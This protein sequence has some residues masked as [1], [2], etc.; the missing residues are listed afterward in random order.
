MKPYIAGAPY[1]SRRAG[2]CALLLPLALLGGCAGQG[3][4]QSQPATEVINR[5]GVDALSQPPGRRTTYFKDHGSIERFCRD[6]NPDFATTAS[7]GV[8]LGIMPTGRGVA[9]DEARGALALGG[10]NPEVLIARELLYRAC[11]LTLNINADSALTLQI[12][13]RFL[14]SIEKIA[15]AQTG[16]G[17]AVLAGTAGDTRTTLVTPVST[18]P[19]DLSA[20][21]L[22][23]NSTPPGALS[24]GPGGQ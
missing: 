10:R 6:A 20:G 17:S 18:L 8:T 12:Y 23:D 19:A 9:N 13:E 2:Y 24:P 4:L 5:Q 7:E 11:E 14:Q 3:L 16:T 21:A 22:V 1:F 15:T